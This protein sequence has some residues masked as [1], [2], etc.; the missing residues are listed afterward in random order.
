N[1]LAG[2]STYLCR[3]VGVALPAC[4]TLGYGVNGAYPID[5][6]QA[7]PYAAGQAI[8]LLTSDSYSRYQ[9]LQ[10][11]YRVRP[12]HGLTVTANYTYGKTTTNRYTD[13]P[14]LTVNY[15]TLR[16]KSYDDGPNV[17]DLRHA[18]NGFMTYELPF[19]SGR[20]FDLGNGVLNQIVGGWNVSS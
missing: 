10:L 1:S 2:N 18:F 16:D 14:A 7:N 20:T 19:G 11:Q 17:F 9:G 4:A 5:F 8:N 6:F 15:T 3:M 12:A 13:S